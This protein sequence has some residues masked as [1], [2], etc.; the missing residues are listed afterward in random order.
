M[1]VCS[2]RLGPFPSWRAQVWRNCEHFAVFCKTGA[3][4]SWQ[5]TAPLDRL[6]R[7][8][9]RARTACADRAARAA[10]PAGLTL[11]GLGPGGGPEPPPSEFLPEVGARQLA[12]QLVADVGGVAA[13][14]AAV[15]WGFAADGLRSWAGRGACTSDT[16]FSAKVRQWQRSQPGVDRPW[17]RQN[18]A[19]GGTRDV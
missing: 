10:N 5:V 18:A 11:L 8:L 17:T 16:V 3:G 9:E 12:G 15:V 19:A 7:N 14:A 6:D 4:M 1:P 2:E 13:D